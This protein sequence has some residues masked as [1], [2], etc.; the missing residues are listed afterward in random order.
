[1]FLRKFRVSRRIYQALFV[2]IIIACSLLFFKEVKSSVASIAH[3][4][5]L[6]HFSVFFVLTGFLKRAFKAP[7]WLYILILAAY[8]AGVEYVQGMIPHR[9]AS[10]ADFVA[11][12]AGIVSYLVVSHF[13]HKRNEKP[14]HSEQA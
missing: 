7:F 4:D 2:V 13:W 12:V 6:A 8:G 14:K 5:K 9:Q 1:M 11:D 3:I 10:F